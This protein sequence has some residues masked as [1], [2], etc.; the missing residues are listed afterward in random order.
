[1]FLARAMA[2]CRVTTSGALSWD[3]TA[4]GVGA[5][6]GDVCAMICA[7]QETDKRPRMTLAMRRSFMRYLPAA[8]ARSKARIIAD[9]I[10]IRQIALYFWTNETRSDS[11]SDAC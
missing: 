6:A 2:S 10:S 4:G 9:S 7:K 3:V 5:A 1:M 11:R 8:T